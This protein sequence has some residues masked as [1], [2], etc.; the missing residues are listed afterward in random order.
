M[1][2]HEIAMAK[3]ELSYR[4]SRFLFWQDRRIKNAILWLDEGLDILN[5]AEEKKKATRKKSPKKKKRKS[6]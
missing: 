2:R 4:R 6:K 5:A 3:H 1:I